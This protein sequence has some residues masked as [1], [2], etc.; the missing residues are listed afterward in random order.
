MDRILHAEKGGP[1][2]KGLPLQRIL[3]GVSYDG[4]EN[5]EEGE[6]TNRTEDDAFRK[7]RN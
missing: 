1:S 6:A 5:N 3:S 4:R 2:A 7:V